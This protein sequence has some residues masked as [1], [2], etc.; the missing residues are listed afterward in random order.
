MK[1]LALEPALVKLTDL[2]G[3]PVVDEAGTTVD[4]SFKNFLLGRLAD[5]RFIQDATH[6]FIAEAI[7]RRVEEANGVLELED[8]QYRKL[9]EVVEKPHTNLPYGH[10]QVVQSMAPFIRA[11]LEKA[12]DVDPS[13]N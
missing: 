2:G 1:Y 12:L 3:K 9:R 7:K 5:P 8:E 4:M 10:P 13:K 11:V 6:V